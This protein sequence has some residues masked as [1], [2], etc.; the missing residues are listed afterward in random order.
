[1]PCSCRLFQDHVVLSRLR[2][3]M[4]WRGESDEHQGSRKRDN[5]SPALGQRDS[6]PLFSPNEISRQTSPCFEFERVPTDRPRTCM[7]WR[8]ET[9]EHQGSRKRDNTSPALGQR[10][11]PRWFSPSEILRPYA[12]VSCFLLSIISQISISNQ[13]KRAIHLHTQQDFNMKIFVNLTVVASM[14]CAFASAEGIHGDKSK[15]REGA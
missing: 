13:S 9:D 15:V 10:D 8:G 4:T 1:V 2:T 11:Y 6:P 14:T 5:T 12:F 7:T 3:S